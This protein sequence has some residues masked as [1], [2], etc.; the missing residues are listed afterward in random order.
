MGLNCQL[1]ALTVAAEIHLDMVLCSLR[2]LAKRLGV[3]LV[4]GTVK[5][6]VRHEKHWLLLCKLSEKRERL[7]RSERNP[8]I[9]W[10]GAFPYYFVSSWWASVPN[11][12]GMISMQLAWQ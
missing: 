8:Y 7:Q 3:V 1:D 5:L 9:L 11:S 12:G 10:L 2:K 6:I 4:I